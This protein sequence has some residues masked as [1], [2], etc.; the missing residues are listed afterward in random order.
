MC[1]IDILVGIPR[2]NP[3]CTLCQ[4]EIRYFT[5]NELTSRDHT[6]LRPRSN[7]QL[8]FSNQRWRQAVLGAVAGPLVSNGS[9]RGSGGEGKGE[10]RP[11][12]MAAAVQ[13]RLCDSGGATAA[14]SINCGGDVK[15]QRR[16]T[17]AF[18]GYGSWRMS[19]AAARG[20]GDIAGTANNGRRL[21]NSAIRE[22]WGA[23][24]AVASRRCGSSAAAAQRRRRQNG[25]D[26]KCQRRGRGAVR[27]SWGVCAGQRRPRGKRQ[28]RRRV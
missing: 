21:E 17:G 27:K 12:A 14:A 19:T 18:W 11:A 23:V 5:N 25:S 24:T 4:T 7:N 26:G 20:S 16:T 10:L 2:P 8:I 6:T 9:G 3:D 13:K 22:S 28:Q 15:R 1:Q